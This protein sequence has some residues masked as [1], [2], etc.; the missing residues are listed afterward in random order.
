LRNGFAS[1]QSNVLDIGA[2]RLGS[3]VD[4]F[5]LSFTFTIRSRNGGERERKRELRFAIS[6][7]SKR[8]AFGAR[9]ARQLYPSS[10]LSRIRATSAS[11]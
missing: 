11:L 1:V 5:S 2:N 10:D 4:T 9:V 7:V 3:S 6:N 8:F